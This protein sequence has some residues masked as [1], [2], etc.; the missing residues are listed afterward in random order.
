MIPVSYNS[1]S[2]ASRPLST[3]VAA[4]GVGSVVFVFAAMWML[5]SSV[6]KTLSSSG[7]PNNA[8]VLAAGAPSELASFY[9]ESDARIVAASPEVATNGDQALASPEVVAIL[10]VALPGPAGE[11]AKIIVR[12]VTPTAWQVHDH[13]GV[14]DGHAFTPGTGE[15]VVGRALA[16]KLR[17]LGDILPVTTSR[18]L[19]IVGTFAAQGASFESEVWG[20]LDVIGPL[21]APPGNISALVVRLRDPGLVSQLKAQLEQDRRLHLDVKSERDYY[22]GQSHE[23][24]IFVRALAV[25]V[26]LIFS[27]GATLGAMTTMYAIVGRRKREIGTLR[28][29]GFDRGSI[30]LC[31]VIESLVLSLAGGALGLAG[32]LGL[33]TMKLVAVDPRTFST[34]VFGFTPDPIVLAASVVVAIVIGV[35]SGFFPAL[36]ASRISPVDAMRG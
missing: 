11:V 34:I 26:G 7:S 13:V 15:V 9:E 29:L 8:I 21:F 12:G 30:L 1:R 5:S 28:A 23:L 36:Y 27:V 14:V 25:A 17:T 32:A 35:A 16:K 3:S 18:A 20:D 22:A 33:S 31:F 2:L 4:L 6:T 19:T 10:N 24:A